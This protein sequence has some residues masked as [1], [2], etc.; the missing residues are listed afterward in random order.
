MTG[1]Y[2]T[3]AILSFNGMV[4]RGSGFNH[5]R[6]YKR[7]VLYITG[8]LKNTILEKYFTEVILILG[9][10]AFTDIIVNMINHTLSNHIS[11]FVALSSS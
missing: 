10:F 7:T 1:Q 4:L 3:N 8:K 11:K 6:I 5:Y 2:T 9:S